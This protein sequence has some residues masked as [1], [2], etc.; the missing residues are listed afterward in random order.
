MIKYKYAWKGTS[1]GIKEN[2]TLQQPLHILLGN[3]ISE[4]VMRLCW[5]TVLP[6]SKEKMAMTC[7]FRQGQ[8]NTDK[9]LN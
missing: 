3:R 1:W 2:T 4:T 7:F 8:M 6:D 5:Q 9:R